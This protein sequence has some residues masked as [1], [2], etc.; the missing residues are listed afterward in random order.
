MNERLTSWNFSCE[1]FSLIFKRISNELFLVTLLTIVIAFNSNHPCSIHQD[2]V[3]S[4]PVS[5]IA[6]T[7]MHNLQ[8]ENTFPLSHSLLSQAPC[9]SLTFKSLFYETSLLGIIDLLSLFQFLGLMIQWLFS[10]SFYLLSSFHVHDDTIIDRTGERESLARATYVF[11][12]HIRE[13][14]RH[15]A[16]VK[17][18]VFVF[19]NIIKDSYTF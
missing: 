13:R 12:I 18:Q 2:L 5:T 9:S 19:I 17:E 16:A 1:W 3:Q 8:S 14:E 10:S 15:E 11:S 4:L 7:V 6:S